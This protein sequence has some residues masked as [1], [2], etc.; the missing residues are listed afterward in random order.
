MPEYKAALAIYMVVNQVDADLALAVK[1]D[2]LA[3]DAKKQGH[4]SVDTQSLLADYFFYTSRYEESWNAGLRAAEIEPY[5][6]SYWANLRAL[7]DKILLAFEEESPA[8]DRRYWLER[9][10]SIPREMERLSADR[11]V[12]VE[13][14]GE[15]EASLGL[16]QEELLA[17]L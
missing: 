5:L 4:Y 12:P 11:W 1:A 6:E 13:P 16:W 15:L 2:K 7:I 17:L 14:N 3:H 8:P 10:L 9:G